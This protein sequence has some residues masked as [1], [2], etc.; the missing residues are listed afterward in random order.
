MRGRSPGFFFYAEA[1]LRPTAPAHNEGGELNDDPSL[2]PFWRRCRSG[3]VYLRGFGRSGAGRRRQR[4]AVSA[5]AARS[6]GEKETARKEKEKE[7]A[8]GAI[9]RRLSAC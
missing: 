2:Q 5:A 6:E 3:A 9:A 7:A 4:I 8:P 1:R